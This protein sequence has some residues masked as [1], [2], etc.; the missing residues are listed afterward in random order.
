MS[1]E[2]SQPSAEA[3]EAARCAL[4]ERSQLGCSKATTFAGLTA[5]YLIDAPA[6]H[7]AGVAEG[8]AAM[9]REVEWRREVMGEAKMALACGDG[10][11]A[12]DALTRHER[13]GY[14][15]ALGVPGSAGIHAARE[16]CGVEPGADEYA[17]IVGNA[18]VQRKDVAI[19]AE[20]FEA[21]RAAMRD[22]IVAF[23]WSFKSRPDDD[24]PHDPVMLDEAVWMS[25]AA[26]AIEAAFPTTGAPD[27]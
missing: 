7:E 17:S 16:A 12:H 3:I 24:S 20:G 19:R 18:D 8:R 5:A 27:A 6:I 25:R 14:P 2:N 22:E 21:G 9:L 4:H 11:A 26:K 15:W 13:D 23:L 1:G 10:E